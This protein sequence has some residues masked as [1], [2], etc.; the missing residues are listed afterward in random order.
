DVDPRFLLDED[1]IG[2]LEVVIGKHWPE[3][4]D[5]A[6]IQDQR[7]VVAVEAARAALLEALNLS[8][9]G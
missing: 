4:L 9:L 1:K 5:P 2:R 7:V 6:A 8:A 3:S